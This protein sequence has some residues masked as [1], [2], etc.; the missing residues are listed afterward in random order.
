MRGANASR[1]ASMSV[2]RRVTQRPDIILPTL[3]VRR[4]FIEDGNT[5]DTDE[6]GIKYESTEIDEVPSAYDPNSGG[7]LIDGMGR[8]RLELNG[9]LQDGYVLVVNDPRSGFGHAL[10]GENGYDDGPDKPW[11]FYEVFIPVAGGGGATV[12]AWVVG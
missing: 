6:L 11:A 4:I 8:G 10:L 9:V 5:L 3:A 2:N 7:T 12:A 1:D